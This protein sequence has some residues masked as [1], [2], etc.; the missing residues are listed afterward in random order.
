M[1]GLGAR[2]R[3]LQSTKLKWNVWAGRQKEVAT[4]DK[5]EMGCVGAGGQEEVATIDKTEMGCVGWE[6][7]K[8]GYNRQN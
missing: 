3:W 5:S 6:P 1:C 8:G 2:K 7:E 4:I